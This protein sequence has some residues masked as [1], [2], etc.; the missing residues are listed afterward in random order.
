[1]NAIS[2]VFRC[3]RLKE[4]EMVILIQNNINKQI[5]L[6]KSRKISVVSTDSVSYAVEHD[7]I[8]SLYYCYYIKYSMQDAIFSSFSL[9]NH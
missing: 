9:L 1:M 2:C 3:L 8:S 5:S 7:P 6:I 4:T